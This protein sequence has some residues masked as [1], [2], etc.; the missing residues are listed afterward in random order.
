MTAASSP[1]CQNLVAAP[2]RAEF[3]LGAMKQ[4]KKA[5]AGRVPLIL[6]RGIGRA[7]I[8]P[9]ADLSDVQR[10]LEEETTGS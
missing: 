3:L 6:T 7:F 1:G 8:Q 5:R 4:D 10:F 9:D 2:I